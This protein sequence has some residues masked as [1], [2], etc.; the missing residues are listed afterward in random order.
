MNV[1]TISLITRG[2]SMVLQETKNEKPRL[3]K[4]RG[5]YA[6]S[7]ELTIHFHFPRGAME[8]SVLCDHGMLGK[9]PWN[10]YAY[11]NCYVNS[12][13]IIIV[14]MIIFYLQLMVVKSV[15]SRSLFLLQR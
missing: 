11:L 8:P 3:G 10:S 5:Q 6:P 12:K 15:T 13:T 4:G 9:L 1:A 7:K 14:I 2:L